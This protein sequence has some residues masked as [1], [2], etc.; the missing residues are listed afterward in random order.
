MPECPVCG[1]D[2][3]FRCF[4]SGQFARTGFYSDQKKNCADKSPIIVQA[5]G[6]CGF[7][8]LQD[9]TTPDVDYTDVN[10]DTTRQ[11]PEYTSDLFDLF[12]QFFGGKDA[13]I[14]EVG[15][16]N[17]TF[18]NEMVKA[19]YSNLSGIEPSTYLAGVA[20][21]RGLK[22]FNAYFD[23]DFAQCRVADGQAVSG[24]ICRHTLEHVPD[25]RQMMQAIH[26]LLC[27]DG[28]GFIEVPD[29]GYLLDKTFCHEIWDEH[30]NYFTLTTL[31]EL[32][33]QVGFE[34]LRAEAWPFRETS[35]LIMFVRKKQFGAHTR[36][37]KGKDLVKIRGLQSAWDALTTSWRAEIEGARGP[38]VA[39]GAS[40]IQM[41]FLNFSELAQYV[42]FLVDDDP[43]KTG[44]FAQF[45]NG[46]PI[47]STAQLFESVR[48]ETLICSAFPYPDWQKKVIAHYGADAC[49][50]MQPYAQVLAKLEI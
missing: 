45:G 15:A 24:I 33:E 11:L 1:R 44:K 42:D 8:R 43:A 36:P 31:Q 21:D 49:Q 30:I 27:D 29:T 47:L 2:E 23:M 34:V 10:R 16:N 28:I 13:S 20:T 17:G 5:C 39:M 32:A 25:C 12:S 14:L 46:V 9:T 4:S 40:H 48:P 3:F 37:H 41:N 6:H 35:N 38:V 18:M 22:V 26:T 7:M 50:I 19:G